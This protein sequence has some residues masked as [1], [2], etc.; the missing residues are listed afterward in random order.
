MNVY[1]FLGKGGVGKTTT[2]AAFGAGLSRKGCNVALVSIDPAHNLGDALD[3]NLCNRDTKVKAGLC[4]VEVDIEQMTR[5]Y[6]NDLSKKMQHTYR[7]L[8]AMNLDKYFNIM[9]LSPGIEEYATLEAI[10]QYIGSKVYDAIVFDTPP[11]G[12]MLRVLAM[13]R[14]SVLWSERLISMR[15]AILSRRKM[16]ENVK[17]KFEAEIEGEK[18]ILTSDEKEDDIMQELIK[19]RQ[20]M[21]ELKNLFSSPSCEIHI[22][23]MAEELALFE[24]ERILKSLSTFGI[25]TKTI[26]LNKFMKMEN[27]PEEIVGKLEEQEKVITAMRE[28]FKNLSIKEIPLL[29][30][31]P[32]GFDELMKLYET[33]IVR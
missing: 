6:L 14:L 8:T 11:T 27:P 23:T 1:F 17:G 32:R 7:Y 29:K 10:R 5:D 4:A 26:Y 25:I 12:I 19:Y 33:Y 18:I 2:S 22:V 31:S 9:K 28:K 30:A 24:T 13:P 21:I 16:I 15:K 20:E 3:V